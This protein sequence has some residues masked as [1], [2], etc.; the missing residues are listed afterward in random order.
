MTR[1]KNAALLWM[2]LALLGCGG[3]AAPPKEDLV[4]VSGTVKI[5][6]KP[7]AGIYVSF[8][9]N[10]TTT[11]Q[12]AAGVTDDEGKY[13]LEHNATHEPGIPVGDYVANLSKWVMPD[14]KPLPKDTAPHMV[15]AT[16]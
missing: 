14:G 2:M 15:N 6:G 5:G 1:C 13:E 16:N 8:V 7:V 11:G 4:P 12:G 9:P 10:G 3:P